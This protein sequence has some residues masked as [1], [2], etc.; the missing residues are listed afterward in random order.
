[1]FR[2]HP[3]STYYT[4]LV[5]SFDHGFEF[6]HLTAGSPQ[7]GVTGGGREVVGGIVAPVVYQS[8]VNE[9]FFIQELM[10]GEQFNG[11]DAQVLQVFD[12][13]GRSQAG[14]C[15]PHILREVRMELGETFDMDFVDNGT[16]PGSAQLPVSSPIKGTF[17]DHAFGYAPGII[18]FIY[19]QVFI[20][21]P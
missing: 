10:D 2:Q 4:G 19:G 17:S 20:F 5:Q 15:A 3:G 9:A 11:G 7:T 1:M 12:N 6:C 14:V 8:F 13:R 18:L 16:V 21:M